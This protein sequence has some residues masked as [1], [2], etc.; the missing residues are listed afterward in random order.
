MD[1]IYLDGRHYDRMF[2]A[3]DA[4]PLLL[5]QVCAFGG[6]VLELA[7]GTGKLLEPIAHAGFATTGVD[8]SE[9]MLAEARRKAQAA[10]STTRYI[11][12]DIRSFA[13]GE[14]FPFIFIAGNSICH[15]LDIDSFDA[16][17]ACVRAHLAEGGRFLIDL[18]V[19]SLPLLLADPT[20]RQKLTAYDDPDGAGRVVVTHTSHYDPISQIKAS[21]TF[22]QFPGESSEREGSL[23]L[24][25]YFPQELQALLRH[26]GFRIAEAYGGYDRS[27]LVSGSPRQIY[28]LQRQ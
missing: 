16:C 12:A 23:V 20:A 11:H 8:L 25:M 27:P 14:R 18:Y 10:G 28:I 2:G 22:H 9:P 17:M 26:N 4:I 24:K 15:L 3:D 13:L 21:R 1:T 19:P 5:E 6:P 7:C